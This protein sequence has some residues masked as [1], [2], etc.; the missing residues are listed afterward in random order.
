MSPVERALDEEIERSAAPVLVRD[1]LGRLGEHAPDLADRL[2]EDRL[3]QAVIAVI[4]A[5]RS[6]TRLI[7]HHPDDALGILARLDGRPALEARTPETLAHWKH[8]EFLRI[9]AR[10]LTGLDE[11]EMTGA[12]LSRLA[13]DVLEGACRIAGTT[14]LAVIGMGKL[15]GNELNYASDIDVM[16]VGDGGRADLEHGARTVMDI[17]RRCFRVDANLRPE[18]RDGPLVRSVDSYEAYWAKWAEP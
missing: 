15:G 1:A 9:A 8:L 5:S 11:L 10:D 16:F 12:A 6:L 18:G 17:A 7:E 13:T 2:A 3:R 14:A 4:A